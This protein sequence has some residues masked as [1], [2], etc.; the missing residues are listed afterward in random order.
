LEDDLKW[1]GEALSEDSDLICMRSSGGSITIPVRLLRSM[2]LLA[3]DRLHPILRNVK[4]ED[5]RLARF[6]ESYVSSQIVNDSVQIPNPFEPPKPPEPPARI[7]DFS[8]RLPK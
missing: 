5:E 1:N 3:I 8:L 2:T 6:F 7:F 4:D